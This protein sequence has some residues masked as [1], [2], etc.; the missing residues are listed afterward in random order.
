MDTRRVPPT[1]RRRDRLGLLAVAVMV[2]FCLVACAAGDDPAATAPDPS[3]T[4]AAPLTTSSDDPA[5]SLEQ[6][7]PPPSR[8]S[9]A[10]ALTS[11]TPVRDHPTPDAPVV[12]TLG[13]TS[14][15]GSPTTLGVVGQRDGWL[16]VQ[17]PVRPNHTTG[18]IPADHVELHHIDWSVHVDL[19]AREL[20]VRQGE[21]TVLSTPV[22]VGIAD[23]PTPSGEFFVTDLLATGDAASPYGPFAFGLSAH[24]DTIT[25]FAGGDGRVGIHGT[26]DPT[27]I[28]TAA[29]HGCV[30]VPNEV[31]EHLATLLPLGT[32]VVIG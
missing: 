20:T 3:A 29:S 1:R 16:E 25:E 31:A 5:P 21:R 14:P 15:Y 13:T 24:S 26:D 7:T 27:S 32:P 30:R 11:E 4:V 10:A 18:W 9:V 12:G 6:A 23:A 8:S 28:G 2:A 17:L 22:A 19:D